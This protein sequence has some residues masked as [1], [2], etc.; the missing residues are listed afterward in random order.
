MQSGSPEQAVLHAVAPQTYGLHAWVWIAGHAP[1]P[2]QLASRVAVPPEQEASRQEVEAVGYA[3]VARTVPSQVPPQAEPSLAQ[4]ARPFAGAPVTG[5]HVPAFPGRLHASHWPPQ[6]VSQQTPSAQLPLTH[7]PAAPQ[8]WPADFFGSQT[9]AL[10]QS[11]AMQSAA[12]LH[13]ARQAVAPHTYGLH[14]CVWI[15]GHAPAPLQLAASVAVPPEQEASRHVAPAAGYVQ[16][17]AFV[18]LQAPPHSEP[19]VAQAA[20]RPTGAPITGAHCP[21]R[22]GTSQASHC[23]L[24]AALQQ[25]PSTQRPEAHSPPAPQPVPRSFTKV[26]TIA[27]APVELATTP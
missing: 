5:E 22:P 12:E 3:H 4:A 11:P 26:A 25:T 14:A 17:S 19:S 8:A 27:C 1:V 9:P 6:A 24:Q 23:P 10:H 7:C 13:E 2:L 21:A 16:E 20:R 15:A 18:P